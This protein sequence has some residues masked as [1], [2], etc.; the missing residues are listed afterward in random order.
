MI[1]I[2]LTAAGGALGW[3]LG[4][5]DGLVYALVALMMA[6]AV[7]GIMRA[8]VEKKLSSFIGSKGIFKKIL[9][10]MLVG[11]ANIVDIYLIKSEN[12]P[13]RTAVLFFYIAN[14]GISLLEN[15]MIIGLP[16]PK[17]LKDVFLELKQ[18][19]DSND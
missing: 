10:F 14:E 16:V 15:A 1:Y 4:G 9:I 7:T 2:I 12:S 13:L 5:F 8:V 17:K 3:Y 18:R 11:V 6:D 19:G